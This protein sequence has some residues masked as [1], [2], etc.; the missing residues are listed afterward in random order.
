MA[1]HIDISDEQF[2]ELRRSGGPLIL[3]AGDGSEVVVQD[4]AAYRRMVAILDELDIA[5]SAE[6]CSERWRRL[7]D[8][9][10]PGVP[11]E[12]LLAD[13]RRRIRRTG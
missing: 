6:V 9:S 1:K 5:R 10:D 8:G 4:A 13:L 3:R 11:A 7:E 12:A 2:D